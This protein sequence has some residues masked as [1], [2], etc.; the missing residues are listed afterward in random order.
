VNSPD[1]IIAGAG[2][3]GVSLAMELR[4]RGA[5][6][7]VL[8]QGTPGQE[9]S[10]AAAGML[11][12]SDPETPVPLRPMALASAQ[13]FPD[14]V[15]KVESLAATSVDFR[16]QGRI[17]LQGHP[18]MPEQFRRLSPE[19]VK[20]IE[21]A[22][23]T[24]GRPVFFVEENSV[25]PALLMPGALQAATSM[26]VEIRGNRAVQQM[27]SSGGQVEI[28][29]GSERLVAKAAVN[30]CGAWSGD[31]VKPRKG[32]MLY[33]Q[34][35]RGGVLEHVVNAPDVYIVPRSS[36][37]ILIGATV[38]DCGYDKGVSAETIEGLR[39]AAIQLVPKLAGAP[40]VATWAGLRPGSPDDLPLLGEIERGIFVAS[41][42]FR[43]G[44][45]L[46]PMTARIMAD[47]VMDQPAEVDISH[48][49]PFRF[50]TSGSKK[51]HHKSAVF[52]KK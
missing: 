36:G 41:G 15:R 47:L 37:K 27:R 34:P 40:V 5:Q 20:R 29:A 7:L 21:P 3:I 19:E 14:Y 16:R 46:A 38:E 2:I 49:S 10:S 9:A 28:I 33:V 52:M 48:F 8:D 1:V 17:V 43:N 45:L 13:L 31:P 39:H 11:S 12:P 25:D 24:G 35:E 18:D 4:E 26:G 23:E 6:V 51:T 50:A 22:L 44:I 32:Q 30:C 42:H